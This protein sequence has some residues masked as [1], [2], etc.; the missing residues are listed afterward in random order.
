MYYC[1]RRHR[2]SR[3]NRC[4]CVV[5]CFFESTNWVIDKYLFAECTE[6]H[7]HLCLNN[8]RQSIHCELYQTTAFF[9][10]QTHTHQTRIHLFIQQQIIIIVAVS[11][12]NK[13]SF[14]IA[15]VFHSFYLLRCCSCRC[16]ICVHQ[17][18]LD[19]QNE[20]EEKR[21]YVNVRTLKWNEGKK[22][23]NYNEGNICILLQHDNT[24]WRW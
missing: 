8:W 21:E 1:H 24:D 20:E 10:S 16:I 5:L 22:R 23:N 4:C 9:L 18:S 11:A 17:K 12:K 2:H 14:H 6:K 15:L 19:E 13:V 3:G 7:L